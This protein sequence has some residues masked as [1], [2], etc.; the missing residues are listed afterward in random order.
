MYAGGTCSGSTKNIP[1]WVID[2]YFL[3]FKAISV[4]EPDTYGYMRANIRLAALGITYN[5]DPVFLIGLDEWESLARKPDMDLDDDF[6]IQYNPHSKSKPGLGIELYMNP[7][8]GPAEFLWMILN[9]R[10]FIT[11]SFHGV[12]FSIIFRK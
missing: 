8:V 4:R 10:R 11:N 5:I 9:C 12:C 2:E 6:D 1:D 7:K 3:K